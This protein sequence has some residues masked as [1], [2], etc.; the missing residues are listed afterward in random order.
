MPAAPTWTMSFGQAGDRPVT[1]D[2]NGD[3]VTD[4]G[5]VRGHEWILTLGP[6]G[7]SEGVPGESGDQGSPAVW[8]DFYFGSATDVPV[9]GDWNG[10]GT[11]G[12]GLFRAGD[13]VP[14][15]AA[16]A[17]RRTRP[18]VSYGTPGDLPVVGDWDGDGTDGLGVARGTRWYLSDSATAPRTVER[19]S[20]PEVTATYRCPGG[21]RSRVA[22]RRA[23]RGRPPL[24]RVVVRGSC[25]APSSAAPSAPPSIPRRGGC[26]VRW[27]RRSATSSA[28]ATTPRGAPGPRAPT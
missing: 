5:V 9:T 26:A 7:D 11:D 15:R 4:L 10:D 27:S 16:R 3:G 25:R 20:S 18:T 24:C 23:R 1:G 28:P 21:C 12:V 13:L 8:R 14:G 17:R 22:T 2:W 6:Y 19:P